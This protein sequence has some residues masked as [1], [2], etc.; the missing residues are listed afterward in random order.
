MSE[1]RRLG[2]TANVEAASLEERLDYSTSQISAK[3]RLKR[4]A[5]AKQDSDDRRYAKHTGA[6]MTKVKIG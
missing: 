5:D 3:R 2:S 6:L 1:D 4:A